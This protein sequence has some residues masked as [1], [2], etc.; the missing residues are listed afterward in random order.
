[1]N[2]TVTESNLKNIIIQLRRLHNLTQEELA[3]RAEVN[4]RTIQRLEKDGSYSPETLRGVADAFDLD[5][6]T[7]LAL[8]KLVPA[9]TDDPEGKYVTVQLREAV[10]GK[11]LTDCFSTV[12]AL[13]PDHP[14]DLTDDQTA[15]V[16]ELLDYFQ[17]Y[18]DIRSDLTPS[19]NL[20]EQKTLGDYLRRLHEVRLRVFVAQLSRPFRFKAGN[21]CEL[22]TAVVQI[23]DENSPLIQP[24]PQGATVFAK[25]EK[26]PEFSL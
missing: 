17:D 23:L 11:A 19:Q 4:V 10:N 7:L 15:V 25:L 12:H 21:P 1:M 5:C 24:L 22:N 6:K 13:Q 20:A 9:G 3:A 14:A 2:S 16:G 18:L 8:A 26:N